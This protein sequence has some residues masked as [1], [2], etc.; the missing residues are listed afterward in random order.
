MKQIKFKPHEVTPHAALRIALPIAGLCLLFA[1]LN[2]NSFN[3]PFERDEGEYAYSAWILRQG[4]LPYLNAFLQKPPLIIYTYL[5]G[6]LIHPTALWTAR[7]LAA[8]FLAGTVI[9]TGLTAR[10]E[11]EN[12]P[13]GGVGIIAMY[14]ALPM[15]LFPVLTPFAANTE[16]FMLLPLM[17]LLALYAF[18]RTGRSGAP[19]FW[20]G[21]LSAL[22]ILYKPIALPAIS[23]IFIVWAYEFKNSQGNSKCLY[24]NLLLALTGIILTSALVLGYFILNGAGGALW[25]TAVVFNRLY[26]Q[27][28]GLGFSSFMN[29][30][31][32]FWRYQ[33]ILFIITA[34]YLVKRPPR[35]RF[36]LG[37]I[38]VS[39]LT[40]YTTPIGHYYI[41]L[42]PFW[43]IIIAVGIA[44]LGQDLNKL[45]GWKNSAAWLTAATLLLILW[46]IREQFLSSPVRL[47]EWVY[48]DVNPFIDS[49]EVARHVSALSSPRDRIFVAGS[50]PQIYY[51]AQR[52]SASRFVITYPLNFS[53]AKRE[54]YQKEAAGDLAENP[55]EIIVVSHHANT[56]LWEP[57]SPGFFIES[58]N[59]LLS[60]QYRLTG[61]TVWKG[62][63]EYSWQ[64]PLSQKDI[65]SAGFMVFK[66]KT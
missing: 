57:G 46:P 39:L 2:W 11:F 37:L 58:L 52:R 5:L 65:P 4:I 18:N 41:L 54:D 25:D 36:Y 51:Y 63:G 32:R 40:I 22:A 47:N 61:G 31:A 28:F 7:L 44:K 64:E 56:S 12:E 49:P 38:V 50:E 17:G 10:K 66:R 6:Q 35:A 19:W 48:G 53:T 14:L 20:G 13:G 29:Y 59:R 8:F 23:Y 42:M 27:S 1:L 55:P 26:A 43:S 30:L 16:R 60:E 15:I 62:G 21:V 45:L 34:W 3:S 33:W 24:R 9:L